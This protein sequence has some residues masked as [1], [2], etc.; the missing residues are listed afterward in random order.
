MVDLL[1]ETLAELGISLWQFVLILLW[2][3]TWKLLALWKAARKNSPWWFVILA[4]VN[5]TGILE[6]L[7]IFIFSEMKISAKKKSKK[8]QVK[9][10]KNK[11]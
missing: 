2:T 10:I 9:K 6:I 4:L 5:T 8:K 1:N 3:Y 7:Y 11:K